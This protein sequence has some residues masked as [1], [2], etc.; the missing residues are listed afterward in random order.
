MMEDKILKKYMQK[1]L[2][3]AQK[4]YTKNEV[5][6]GALIIDAQ[7][8]IIGRG[9]NLVEK[10]KQQLAHAEIRAISQASRKRQDWRLDDCWLFV[11][12]E[13]CSLCMNLILLSRLKGV[14]F[15]AS[16]PLYGY[17]LDKNGP[18]QLYRRNRLHIISGICQEEAMAL[19]K[20]FF[21]ARRNSSE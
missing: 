7:G 9:H 13:P 4:A 6:I 16:S 14:V 19:L 3:E 17:G 2:K 21:K 15:G 20:S 11:T 12:L 10:T 8:T 18:I 1:A 5:P